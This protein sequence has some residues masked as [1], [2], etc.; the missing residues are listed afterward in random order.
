MVLYEVNNQPKR[1]ASYSVLIFEVGVIQSRIICLQ[2]LQENSRC[3]PIMIVTSLAFILELMMVQ[4]GTQ[5]LRL[6]TLP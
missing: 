1:T 3:K 2:I 5:A 4:L 6:L